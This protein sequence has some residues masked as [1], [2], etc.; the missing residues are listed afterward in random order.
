MLAQHAE[1]VRLIDRQIG[2]VPR[3]D[4]GELGERRLIAEHTV[5]ALDDDQL[6]LALIG[7]SSQATV[8]ILGVVVAEAHHSCAAEAAAVVNARVGVGIRQDDVPR[9][10][11]PREHAQVSLVARREHE[12]A[13][14]AHEV[15]DL[16]LERAV[17]TIGA[18]G[19]ARAGGA[20]AVVP[21]RSDRLLDAVPI[22]GEAEVVVGPHQDGVAPVD[23]ASSGGQEFVDAHAEGIGA[24]LDD[25]AVT[26]RNQRILVEDVHEFSDLR[27]VGG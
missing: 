15:G 12:C 24:G 11:K 16:T 17:D 13:A 5:D 6:A 22:E 7:Q 27:S 4:L 26:S 10:R 25:F 23:P 21:D 2:A 3:L 19:N 8:E 9:T 1:R 14:A 18:I 20:G